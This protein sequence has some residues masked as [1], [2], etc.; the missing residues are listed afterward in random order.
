MLLYFV[1]GISSLSSIGFYS[2]YKAK[3]SVT[4]KILE[5]LIQINSA[6]KESISL[7]FSD[8]SI[9]LSTIKDF[10]DSSQYLTDSSAL[11]NYFS[12]Y[13]FTRYFDFLL[14]RNGLIES[15]GQDYDLVIRDYK[16][17]NNV[18]AILKEKLLKTK[19]VHNELITHYI[20]RDRGS[21]GFLIGYIRITD[22]KDSIGKYLIGIVETSTIEKYLSTPKNKSNHQN[23]YTF[24]S[25]D[26]EDIG[27]S[28]YLYYNYENGVATITKFLRGGLNTLRFSSDLYLNECKLSVVTEIDYDREMVPIHN[29]RN[30]IVFISLLILVLIF[31]IGN[32]ITASII[33]PIVKL[34]EAAKHLGEGNFDSKVEVNTENEFRVL[35]LAFN[36]MSE[37]IKLKTKEMLDREERLKYFYKVTS[38]GIVFIREENILMANE[39]F[40][41]ITQYK[42]NRL[43]KLMFSQIVPD[44]ESFKRNDDS[45]KFETI[46]IREDGVEVA[47]EIESGECDYLGEKVDV[48]VIHNIT[49]RK[50]AEIDLQTERQKS[51]LALFDGQELERKR[52]SRELHDSIGQNLIA[53]KLKIENQLDKGNEP[54]RK[55]LLELGKQILFVI[56]EIKSICGNLTPS[57]INEFNLDIALNNFCKLV[58]TNSCIEIN[59]ST[60]GKFD[61]I[62]EKTKIFLYRIAQEAINNSIKHS[63]ASKIHLHLMSNSESIILIQEDNGK[64]FQIESKSCSSGNGI[65]NMKE[66][67]QLLGG[68]FII[69][70]YENQGTTIRVKI[71]KNN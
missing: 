66:R 46:I 24:I 62:N 69:E 41:R 38:E 18:N 50:K 4:N 39:A 55:E 31:S 29:L 63:N 22:S 48:F 27:V 15:S 13:G 40:E 44:F 64:G 45:R 67:T 42:A 2:Y 49:D 32:V 17:I 59:F 43:S 65:Y 53:L 19:V 14:V 56:N 16:N 68:S 5:E 6:K 25:D 10:L 35:A 71:P 3:E 8:I 58:S 28:E 51:L 60:F 23:E 34:Q 1:V 33:Q 11:S 52:V 7:I 30:D 57:W 12:K 21:K 36:K 47:V 26:N 9:Q 54:F 61:N 70:S 20:K 37:Q